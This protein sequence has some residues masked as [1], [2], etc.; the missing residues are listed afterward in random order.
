MLQPGMTVSGVVAFDGTT[1]PADMSK[2]R[3]TLGPVPGIGSINGSVIPQTINDDASFK[4]EGV[5]PSKYRVAATAPASASGTTW[6]LKS[7]VVAGRDTLD[8]ALDVKPGENVSDLVLTFGNRPT[9]ISG[10]LLDRANQPA[11]GYTILVFSTDASTWTTGSRRTKQARPAADGRFTIPNLPAGSY[12]MA[13]LTDV[14]FA[15]LSDSTFLEQV[16]ASALRIE[17]GD[18]EKK[19]QDLKIAGL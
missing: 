16:A 12:F 10:R 15:D 9:E 17:L 7:A 14:D 2:V 4:I 18:G 19:R 3:V 5:V 6:F 13:A 11:V 1:P 8:S